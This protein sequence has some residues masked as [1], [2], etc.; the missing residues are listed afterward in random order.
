MKTERITIRCSKETKR[1][2]KAFKE[3]RG[4][5]DLEEMINYLIDY[6]EGRVVRSF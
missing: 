2:V 5:R 1:K 3:S 6:Y 4:F